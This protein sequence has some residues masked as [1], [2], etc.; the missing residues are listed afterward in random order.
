MKN[1][2]RILFLLCSYGSVFNFDCSLQGLCSVSGYDLI[3]VA[4]LLPVFMLVF[5]SLE[6]LSFIIAQ[7]S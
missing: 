6:H 2:L 5:T 7:M 1:F 4:F 3:Q